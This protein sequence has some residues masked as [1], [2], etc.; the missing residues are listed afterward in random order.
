MGLFK[1]ETC[2]HCGAQA[3]AMSRQKLAD[4]TYLCWDCVLKTP[5][6]FSDNYFDKKI[7]NHDDYVRFLSHLE[8]NKNKLKEFEFSYSFYD[9]VYYDVVHNWFVFDK[10]GK[11]SH[12]ELIDDNAEVFEGK[13]L[14][15]FDFF[16]EAQVQEGTF[17]DKAYVDTTLTVAFKNEWY[18]CAIKEK[19]VKNAKHKISIFGN[20]SASG[21]YSKAAS[22]NT[23]DLL[24]LLLATFIEN[25]IVYPADL[26]GKL[27]M[28]V[29][30]SPYA[31]YFQA[32]SELKKN[33]VFSG[34]ELNERL[35]EI[36]PNAI[37]KSKIK[38]QFF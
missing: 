33:G 6:Y 11:K 32:M 13:D 30:L 27:T 29:D 28:N 10:K 7:K 18:P 2:V 21:S 4:G 23:G 8:E 34:S 26:G 38:Q 20:V 36:A 14:V 5:E 22:A 25:G 37:V 24:S 16:N 12:E 19:V 17:K 31:T 9:R 1:K 3:G 35:N 15:Y